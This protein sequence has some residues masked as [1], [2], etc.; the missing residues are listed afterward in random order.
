MRVTIAAILVV[1][2]LGACATTANLTLDAR[3]LSPW[4]VAL[5][6]SQIEGAFVMI[7]RHN[8]QQVLLV[9]AEHDNAPDS[10]TF[11]LIDAAFTLAPVESV[12]VEGTRTAL[13]PDPAA[14]RALSDE[15]LDAA[16]LQPNGETVPTVRGALRHGATL[17]GGEP[18]EVDVIER[19][20][21]LG[22]TPQ[23]IAGF[24]VLRVIPQWLRDGSASGPDDR[25]MIALIERQLA[26][27][28]VSFGNRDTGLSTYA[29][30]LVWY[31]RTNG[32]DFGSGFDPEE[33]GPLV[34]GPWGSNKIAAA[35]ARAR[36]SHLLNVIASTLAARRSVM[37]VYGASHA[38]ILRGAL[39]RR[40]GPP[41]YL[42]SDMG[43]A[44]RRCLT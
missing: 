5:R 33:T 15:S 6:D 31:R 8:E 29:D 43:E 41:C 24:Y 28:R 25:R 38:L 10:A 2:C 30:W 4:T 36:D 40:F 14:L 44:R 34:D 21:G 39:E 42:G 26:R 23:D 12:I 17:L 27:V 37:V 9:G 18:E 13:G 3:R 20:I 1:L 35:V 11:Q 16:G 19:A 32:R 7:F 22:V